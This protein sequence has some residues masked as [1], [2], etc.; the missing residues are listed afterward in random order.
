M[1][2]VETINNALNYYMKNHH[3][4]TNVKK[5][6]KIFPL[7]Q[8]YHHES[9][10]PFDELVSHF[11]DTL[12]KALDDYCKQSPQPQDLENALKLLANLQ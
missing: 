2:E 4:D 1:G 3:A 6:L 8:N 5:L 10:K 7:T 11:K 12:K 9:K